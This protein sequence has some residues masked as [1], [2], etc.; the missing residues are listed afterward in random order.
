MNLK[1]RENWMW[2]DP[3]S[4]GRIRNLLIIIIWHGRGPETSTII[5]SVI[6]PSAQTS[7]DILL[8]AGCF[9][10]GLYT[11]L[12]WITPYRKLNTVVSKQMSCGWGGV[13]E[14]WVCSAGGIGWPIVDVTTEVLRG[15]DSAPSQPQLSSAGSLTHSIIQYMASCSQLLILW[16]WS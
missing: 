6:V 5:R 3:P 2:V 13:A 1:I 9:V 14:K 11:P 7:S 15:H 10:L 12:Q 4:Y 16:P 8:F